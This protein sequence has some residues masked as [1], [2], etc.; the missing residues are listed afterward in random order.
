MGTVDQAHHL[1]VPSERNY[2]APL[3]SWGEHVGE[4]GKWSNLD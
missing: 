4:R 1:E 3:C 2:S